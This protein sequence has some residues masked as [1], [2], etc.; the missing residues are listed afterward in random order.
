MFAF[1]GLLKDTE[2]SASVFQVGMRVVL[3]FLVGGCLAWPSPVLAFAPATNLAFRF[4]HRASSSTLRYAG[5][6]DGSHVI[7][8]ATFEPWKA[9]DFNQDGRVDFQDLAL[10]VTTALDVNGDGK[11]DAMMA[12]SSCP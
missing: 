5:D 3:S 9:L 12:G 7:S 11:I 10:L 8:V 4:T 2:R 6:E 1:R